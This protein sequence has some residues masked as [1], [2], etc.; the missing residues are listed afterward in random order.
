M[1]QF[2][3]KKGKE[4]RKE[5]RELCLLIGKSK[6]K[7]IGQHNEK[8]DQPIK[9]RDQPI[10][11]GDNVDVFFGSFGIG[12]IKVLRAHL[13]EGFKKKIRE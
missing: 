2:S 12:D 9:R 13:L 11:E 1:G 8:R 3:L 6:K 10:K 4:G 7:Q 5:G